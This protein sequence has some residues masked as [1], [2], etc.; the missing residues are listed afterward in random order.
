MSSHASASVKCSGLGQNTELVL[1]CTKE[2]SPLTSV[3]RQSKYL[4]PASNILPKSL[5][6]VH[7]V[8]LCPTV[9]A[10]C[11]PSMTISPSLASLFKQDIYPP[12]YSFL[13]PHAANETQSIHTA[14]KAAMMTIFLFI[15]SPHVDDNIIICRYALVKRLTYI[16]F[17]RTTVPQ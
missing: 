16:S 6:W 17:L 3:T 13:S 9:P 8:S 11:A 15:T 7:A 12:E 10:S 2:G 14:A 5:C 4:T 1:P